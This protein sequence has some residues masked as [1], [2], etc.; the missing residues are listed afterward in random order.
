M[1]CFRLYDYMGHN[2]YAPFD[3]DYVYCSDSTE[4]G[5]FTPINPP[6]LPCNGNTT[7]PF[8]VRMYPRPVSSGLAVCENVINTFGN[9]K[10]SYYR[11]YVL[12]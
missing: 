10:A 11:L 6:I 8:G 5:P 7:T 2:M 1:L 12:R 9:L 4:T 3:I